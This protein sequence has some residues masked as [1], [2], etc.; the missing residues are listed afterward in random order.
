MSQ[1][2]ASENEHRAFI[3]QQARMPQGFRAGTTRFSFTPAEVAKPAQMNLTL[4][5]AE[6]PT[7]DF[8]AV[9]TRNA[10]AGAPV[11]IGR[12]R[13][14]EAAVSAVVINNK[15]SNVG[16][17]SGQ[18]DAE[19]VCAAVGQ[20]LG[21]PGT[22]VLPASTG[23]I[24]WKLPVAGMVA[25][26]PRAVESLSSESLADAAAA[27]MTTDLYPK[28]RTAAVGAGCI[29]GIVKG[30]GM[31]EPNM[32]TMLGFI[33]T[34]LA[35]P[36]ERLRALLARV[37]ERTFNGISIDSDTSTSD[38]VLLMS[39]GLVPCPD[40]SAF[41]AAL[42]AV[43]AHLAE[44]V[45]RNGE[46]VHHVI[47]VRV[48]GVANRQWARG[49]G[50]A[51]VNSPLVK[52]AMCGN[53][54]NVGRL[55]GAIGKVIGAS[56]WPLDPG[57][58]RVA[59]GGRTLFENGSFTL[60]TKLEAELRAHLEDAELYRSQPTPDGHFH[61]PL[62]FPPHERCVEI[63]ISWPE[64]GAEEVT[65]VGADLSHEYVTENADYRS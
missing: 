57:N 47:R 40:E 29:T 62:C 17:P 9:F 64:A 39:S 56:G 35:V 52:T 33:L 11:V 19:A 63:D 7:P 54:P 46:G 60:S 22:A 42:F 24:G 65:V 13:L 34:D 58:A 38:M 20:A 2:F 1:S 55:L 6:R 51:V 37:V 50:K 3:A 18:A 32:A 8:A 43:C 10:V 16:A 45:V 41:E 23:V 49:I 5:A 4:L 36:R 44:D 15:I 53:D 25:A 27:I 14:H 59:M 28:A 61:P 21:V 26:V 31:I 30:A 12:R 48:R